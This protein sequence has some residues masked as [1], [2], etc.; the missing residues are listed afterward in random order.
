MAQLGRLLESFSYQ[1]V[2]AR[3]FAVV[4]DEAGRP[5][6]AAA[7]L[8]GG[9]AVSLELS[10]GRKGARIEGAQPGAKQGSLF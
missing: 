9:Q 2:L 5:V 6:T 8:K 10:D 1:G 4:R 7:T 3:G